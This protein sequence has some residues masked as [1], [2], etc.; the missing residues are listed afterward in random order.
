MQ[1]TNRFNLSRHDF[2]L[3]LGLAIIDLGLTILGHAISNGSELSPFYDPFTQTLLHMVL[4]AGIYISI[5]LI[6]NQYLH[7]A[8]RT[9]L[10][11]AAAGMHVS[12]IASWVRHFIFP[13]INAGTTLYFQL[14]I[15]AFSTAFIYW[16]FLEQDW[17]YPDQNN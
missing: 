17:Q 9:I 7:H 3:V 16:L 13:W 10:A 14:M 2:Q 5:V 15:T 8:P 6:C 1:I 12:G 11:S 4:G